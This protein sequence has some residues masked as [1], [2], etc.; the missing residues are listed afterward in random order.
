M[1]EGSVS[2]GVLDEVGRGGWISELELELSLQFEI[3]VREDSSLDCDC[4]FE[5]T[6]LEVHSLCSPDL[7]TA[8]RD[9]MIV[10]LEQLLALESQIGFGLLV[11]VR[12][13]EVEVG[14]FMGPGD[15]RGDGL[16]DGNKAV[17]DLQVRAVESLCIDI[18]HA[19]LR[20]R[21]RRGFLGTWSWSWM[22]DFHREIQT[23]SRCVSFPR[24]F[25]LSTE[26]PRIWRCLLIWIR[27]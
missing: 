25:R 12:R 20:G 1:S 11:L 2:G 14:V 22:L 5:G 19:G 23:L 26:M 17:V 18:A 4:G 6:E 24:V 16:W 8:G 15:L 7:R 27:G 13:Q 9:Q 10:T 3:I 21:W